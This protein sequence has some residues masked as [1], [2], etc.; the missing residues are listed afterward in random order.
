MF[1]SLPGSSVH[2]I[3]QERILEWAAI[4]FSRG[5]SRLRNRTQVSC[6]AEGFFHCLSHQW[7]PSMIVAALHKYKLG[8]TSRAKTW[9]R[10]KQPNSIKPWWMDTLFIL[11]QTQSPFHGSFHWILKTVAWLLYL[12]LSCLSSEE[13]WAGEFIS[14]TSPPQCSLHPGQASLFMSNC[15]PLSLLQNLV[16]SD[17]GLGSFQTS[18]KPETVHIVPTVRKQGNKQKQRLLCKE[19]CLR[20]SPIEVL[21]SKV[22]GSDFENGG[23]GMPMGCKGAG[24]FGDW[25]DVYVL[26]WVKQ[27]ASGNALY[28]TGRSAQGSLVT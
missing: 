23:V 19:A 14:L 3:L 26:P 6:I 10:K 4:P 20:A 21:L 7:R 18:Q 2:G 8:L 1:C 11:S 17:P 27:I 24:K 16:N 12:A 22:K 15:E 28:S 25:I 9:S 13:A 5:S